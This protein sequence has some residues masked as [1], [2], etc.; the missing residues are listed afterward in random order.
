M[1]LVIRKQDTNLM[2]IDVISFPPISPD[3][4]DIILPLY[5]HPQ[6]VAYL[7]LNFLSF[8]KRSKAVISFPKH[9]SDCLQF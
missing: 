8:K 2:H 5:W 4:N 3:D 6:T 9:F 7:C 1:Y